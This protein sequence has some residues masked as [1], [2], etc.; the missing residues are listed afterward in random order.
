MRQ[1]GII[2]R[3][4]HRVI[5]SAGWERRIIAFIAGA[6]GALAMAPVDLFPLLA[7]PMCVAVWLI[8]G[9]AQ[10]SAKTGSLSLMR[11][12]IAAAKDGWWLGFGYFVAGLWWLGAAFLVEA[13]QFAWALPLGVL[14]LPA[15]LAL[16]T[17]LGFFVARLLWSSGAARILA[18][19]AGVGISEWLRG[20]VLTGFPWNS[21]GLQE[22]LKFREMLLPREGCKPIIIAMKKQLLNLS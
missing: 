18:L 21:F 4:A 7:V 14:G 5:L 11:S 12:A 15:G 8:D 1:D 22:I 17:A 20:I 3:A 19:A 2:V 13:D 16:F 10:A 6:V 9:S